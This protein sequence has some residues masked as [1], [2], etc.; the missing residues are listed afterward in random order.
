MDIITN[1]A[2]GEEAVGAIFGSDRDKG[3][4]KD[5]DPMSSS[6]GSKRNKKKKK[7]KNQQ[8]KQEAPAD[9]LVTVADR[10]K[11]RGPPGGGIFDKMLKEP[12][13]YHKGPTNHN[14]EDCHMLWRYFESLGTKKDDKREDPNEKG[15][16]KGEGFHE[17]HDCF[18]IYGGPSTRL[19]T[20]Q[21]KQEHREVFSVQLATLLFLDWSEV[22]ITFD[23][24]DH[25]DYV[26]N[27]RIYPLVVDPIIANTHLTKV[28]MDG[29]SSLNIIYAHTLDLLG[30]T[31]THLRPSV[32]GFH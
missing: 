32:G 3:K 19:S 2:T 24:D 25:P 15:D 14:L 20:R 27:P 22:A 28:L 26:P 10:K 13:S 29:G 21:R 31:R 8:G 9:N 12:C 6:R 23:R 7:K 11:P 4:R 30:V 17:I 18:M 1:F 16:N 5:E